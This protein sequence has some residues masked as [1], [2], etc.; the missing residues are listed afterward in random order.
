M[1]HRVERLDILDKHGEVDGGLEPELDDEL[2]LSMHR[3]M[4][5]SRRL[6][7]RML[8]LQGSGDLG[9]FAPAVGQEAAQVGSAACLADTDWM[10]PSFRETPAYLWRGGSIDNLLLYNAGYNE[11]GEIPDDARDFPISIPVAT[12]IPHAVGLAY[13]AK[14]RETEEVALVYFGD[15]ATSEGDFHEGMNFAGALRTPTVF[16]CQNN[17]WAIS[18]PR[19]DQTHSKTL[20]QK[21]LA[22]GMPGIQVDGNDLLAVYAAAGEAVERARE[23]GGP[24]LIE[25]VTYRLEKHTTVDDPSQYRDEE[26]V[27]KRWEEEPLKRF[28]T[29]L[30]NKDLLDDERISELEEEL[31]GEVSEAWDRAKERIESAEGAAAMFEHV[32]D[33]PPAYLAEQRDRLEAWLKEEKSNG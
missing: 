31:D 19:E 18:V 22:Y 1:K 27:E 33:E 20:A 28:Q 32:Y 10:V 7:R 29:Y 6:D 14:Y 16:V 13:A 2:L 30:K 12:Q 21:A 3:V 11:G 8:K 9:T 15:G 5:L 24:T 23:G 4:L 25:C 26:E 17:Q